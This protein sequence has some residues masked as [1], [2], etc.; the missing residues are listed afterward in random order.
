MKSFI[1]M[2]LWMSLC[3]TQLLLAQTG[4]SLEQA[5][6][7]LDQAQSVADYESMADTFEQLAA[8]QGNWLSHYYAAF[9]Y[10][11]IGFLYQ[12]EG[13]RIEHYSKQGKEQIDQAIALI[14]TVNNKKDYAE[15]L[16]VQSL[17]YRTNVYINP[18]TYGP[19]FGPL[20]DQSL[21]QALALNANNP[22]AIYVAAWLKYYTPKAWG[23][24]KDRARELAQKSL[25]LLNK[26]AKNGAQ[27]HWGKQENEVLL[28]Q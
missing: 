15:A 25:S 16:V 9:C 21:K 28:N 17:V 22:R 20:S 27:P 26:E 2:T 3:S 7:H 10:A 18:M 6:S 8:K 5:V 1:I 23:G 12:H 13:E 24:D 11:K 4:T 14:D 19:K